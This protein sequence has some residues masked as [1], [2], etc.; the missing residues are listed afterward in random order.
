[1]FHPVSA[2]FQSGL[3]F[4]PHPVPARPWDALAVVLPAVEAGRTYG[5]AVFHTRSMRRGRAPSIRRR[6]CRQRRSQQGRDLP[7]RIP[8]GPGL[9]W[10]AAYGLLPLTTFATVHLVLALP[11]QP[12]ALPGCCFQVRTPLAICPTETRGSVSDSFA[13]SDYSLRTCRWAP[14]AERWV[15]LTEQLSC[16]TFTSHPC[17]RLGPFNAMVDVPQPVFSPRDVWLQER[18][19]QNALSAFLVLTASLRAAR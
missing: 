8:F 19:D 7:A 16:A 3:R 15:L 2:P 9:D 5:V 6:G 12:L 14:S 13:R 11:S 1:M 4:F 18:I 10:T 17:R